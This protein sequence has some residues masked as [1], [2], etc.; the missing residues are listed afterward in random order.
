MTDNQI[1]K[2]LEKNGFSVSKE[3]NIGWEIGQY[4]PAGEDWCFYV[5]ELSDIK[6]YSDNFDP[7]DE[8]TM[9][10]QARMYNWVRGIPDIPT[11]WKDQMWKQAILKKVAGKIK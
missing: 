9:W 1:I 2:I 11:L 5:D 3:E 8:F 4:T 6:E 7:E 10:A